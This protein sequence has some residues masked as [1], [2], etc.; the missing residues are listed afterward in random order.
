MDNT[1]NTTG[2]FEQTD[3]DILIYLVSDEALEAAGTDR[4]PYSYG[5]SFIAGCSYVG[6][7]RNC[8]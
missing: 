4:G 3:E 7:G 6:S 2:T 1:S 8:C 5:N